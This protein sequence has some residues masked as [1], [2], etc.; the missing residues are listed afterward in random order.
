MSLYSAAKRYSLAV[1]TV[2]VTVTV[3]GII[4]WALRG[5]VSIYPLPA[6]ATS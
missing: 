5:R 6:I 1:A 4:A 2:T 3:A